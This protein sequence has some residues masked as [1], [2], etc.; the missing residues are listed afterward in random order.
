ML[1]NKTLENCF[2]IRIDQ[3]FVLTV[4]LNI[5]QIHQAQLMT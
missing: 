3:C 1:V 4:P 2:W 5:Y